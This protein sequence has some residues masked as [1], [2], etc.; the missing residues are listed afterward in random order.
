MRLNL[1][2]ARERANLSINEI[3][4]QLGITE[5]FYR[6]IESGQRVGKYTHWDKLQALFGI[7]QRDLRKLETKEAVD[8]DGQGPKQS[9]GVDAPARDDT[10]G[11]G[12]WQC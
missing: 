1:I 10:P 2:N 8:E 11:G 3:S 12:I 7:D 5:R 6:Y 9:A 4:K